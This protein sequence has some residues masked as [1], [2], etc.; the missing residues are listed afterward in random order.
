MNA[1]FTGLE[2]IPPHILQNLLLQALTANTS[3]PQEPPPPPPLPAPVIQAD[4]EMAIELEQLKRRFDKLNEKMKE[5]ERNE[6]DENVT[7]GDANKQASKS[8][9]LRKEK[10]M[11]KDLVGDLS[12][13][14]NTV[15]KE[16][17]VRIIQFDITI[18]HSTGY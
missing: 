10:A 3:Q 2:N 12:P 6:G 14:Q 8:K 1:P 18:D 9:R 15:Q 7:P 4:I 13:D 16:L 11:K 5:K 17:V